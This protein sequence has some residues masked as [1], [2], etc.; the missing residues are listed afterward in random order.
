MSKPQSSPPSQDAPARSSRWIIILAATLVVVFALVFARFAL[1]SP[2][3][4]AEGPQGGSTLANASPFATATQTT[5][6]TTGG[7][8]TVVA[9]ATP[10]MTPVI[11]GYP[12]PNVISPLGEQAIQTANS[13]F[14]F[15]HKIIIVSLAGQ[16]LQAVQDGK[17]VLW[18][19]VITGRAELSTPPG[20]YQIFLKDS[21]LTFYP[22]STDPKSP[23]FGYP[24]KVQY[25]MEFLTNGFYIHDAWWHSIYGPGLSFWH[26]DPGR[27]EM[28]ECSHGCVNTPLHAMVFLFQ[29][30]DM[31]TPVEV[32]ND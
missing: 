27:L 19:Y 1:F 2:K 25:G 8:G 21:P 15:H 6:G 29:W 9:G 5:G 16:Y 24:S 28:Q 26:Y 32:L 20:N 22:V 18:T 14:G 11:P 23:F 17:I 7:S 12:A 31:G 30:A 3:G 13:L 10:Y 4:A